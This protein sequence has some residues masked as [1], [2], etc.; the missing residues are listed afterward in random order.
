[1]AVADVGLSAFRFQIAY[2]AQWYGSQMLL[3]DRWYPSSKTCS[4]W[5]QVKEDL[6]WSV[7]TYRCADC[8]LIIDRDSNAARNLANLGTTAR[9]AGHLHRTAFPGTA[10]QGRCGAVQVSQAC[11]EDLRP[12]DIGQTSKKQKPNR[13]LWAS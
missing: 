9:S 13:N 3:A 1:M 10:R 4:A 11:G 7:R 2:K 6:P 8:G 12:G 5:G